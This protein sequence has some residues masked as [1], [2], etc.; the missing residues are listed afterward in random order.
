[1]LLQGARLTLAQLFGL[2]PRPPALLTQDE[3]DRVHQQSR[4]RNDSQHECAICREGFK[5]KPQVWGIPEQNQQGKVCS[6]C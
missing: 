5:D 4:A 2:I 1:M 6:S 3:W